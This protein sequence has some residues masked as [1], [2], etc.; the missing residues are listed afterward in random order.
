MMDTFF[1]G[2]W[3]TADTHMTN[4]WTLWIVVETTHPHLGIGT[5]ERNAW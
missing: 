3:D 4:I 5:Q 2:Q 1:H